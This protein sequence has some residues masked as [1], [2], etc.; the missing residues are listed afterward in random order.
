MTVPPSTPEGQ[1]FYRGR[2]GSGD[3]LGYDCFKLQGGSG[4]GIII[5]P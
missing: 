2:V 1:Y 3:R 5:T 4:P